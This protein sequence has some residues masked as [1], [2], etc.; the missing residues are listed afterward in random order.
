MYNMKDLKILVIEDQLDQCAIIVERL[1]VLTRDDVNYRVAVDVRTTYDQAEK[2]LR[3]NVYDAILVD[4]H[5]PGGYGGE[6]VSKLQNEGELREDANIIVV[7]GRPEDVKDVVRPETVILAKPH[8]YF[9]LSEYLK[10]FF[11]KGLEVAA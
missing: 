10:K 7:T 8:G 9:E 3:A 6:L 4:N 5:I 1:E 2:A 11:E